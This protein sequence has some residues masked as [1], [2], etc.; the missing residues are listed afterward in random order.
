KEANDNPSDA[1]FLAAMADKMQADD[2]AVRCEEAYER[3]SNRCQAACR[4][5]LEHTTRRALVEDDP[6]YTDLSGQIF[7]AVL[8]ALGEIKQEN[9]RGEQVEDGETEAEVVE[10]DL[11]SAKAAKEEEGAVGE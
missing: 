6:Q 1:K 2:Q 8:Q 10:A 5:L 3:A 9:C 4:P 7:A 11:A